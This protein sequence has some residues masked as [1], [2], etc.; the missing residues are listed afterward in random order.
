MSIRGLTVI[1]VCILFLGVVAYLAG[2]TSNS[3]S[4]LDNSN[5]TASENEHHDSSH[6]EKNVDVEPLLKDWKTPKVAFVFTGEQHGYM[7]PC[8][9]SDT[10]SGGMGRRDDLFQKLKERKWE[11]AALD[12]G[13]LSHNNR[14]DRLQSKLK[15][16]TTLASLADMG[17]SAVTF[18]P[19]EISFPA[20]ELLTLEN[21]A[22]DDTAKKPFFVCA[23]V[24]L[25]ETPEMGPRRNYIIEKNGLKI[26]VTGVIGKSIQEEFFPAETQ[27]DIKIS[28]PVEAI[29]KSLEELKEQKIDL[30]VLHSHASM[31]ESKTYIQE[32]PELN[33]VLSAGGAEDPDDK[34]IMEGK[35][36]LLNVGHKGKYA[37]VVGYYPES[38]EK[39]QFELVDLD[40]I[41]FTETERMRD[42][43]RAYQSL[44]KDSASEVLSTLPEAYHPSGS[45]F[46]G[47]E[48]CAKC[49]KKAYQKWK[50]TQHAR[51]YVT[52]EEGPLPGHYHNEKDAEREWIPRIHDPE[53]LSCHTTGWEPQE[54][55]PYDSGFKNAEKSSH[56]KG[57]QCENCHGPANKHVDLETIW[58]KDQKKVSLDDVLAQ[59]K[60]LHMDKATA[61]D[62]CYR[63]HDLNN[64]PKFNFELAFP[65]I[66]HQGRD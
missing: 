37:G 22:I 33:I 53:C 2:W 54:M 18:G 51:A 50:T 62:V 35:T 41:R 64:S 1:A 15:L 61:K 65:K 34:K 13:G 63:C 17:Y 31:D 28:D 56:L 43:M 4:D 11:V 8:G 24:T 5:S 32:F 52:L 44:L 39:Y 7:E 36:L 47:V 25:F 66:Q 46:A 60:R 42:H 6:Q 12:L 16:K 48:T 26:G 20:E 45:T 9:C 49:H 3:S 59:R 38:E 10:Q 29:K 58:K 57:N 19:E 40:N 27:T 55:Y 14:Q 21:V 30:L 23:N